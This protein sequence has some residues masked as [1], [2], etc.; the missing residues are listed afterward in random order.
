M[1]VR[2]LPQFASAAGFSS[3]SRESFPDSASP[4]QTELESDKAGRAPISGMGWQVGGA[5]GYATRVAT[6]KEVYK[7]CLD[8]HDLPPIFHYW[9][10]RHI[11]PKLEKFGISTPD[12]LFRQYV[13]ARFQTGTMESRI[14]SLGAGNCQLEVELAL[15]LV[16]EQHE[17]FTIDCLELNTAML[18]RGREAAVKAGVAAHLNFIPMDLNTWRPDNE[19]DTVLAN[20][21]LHHVLN[22]EGLFA[23]VRK[24]LKTGGSFIVS[25]MIGRNGHLRWPEALDLVREFWRRLPPS[26]RFNQQLKRYEEMFE[27]WDCSGDSFEGIRCQ[28]ILPLLIEN[29]HFEFFFAFANIISP[30]VERS[31]GRSFDPATPWDKNFIDEVNER[32]EHEIAEARIQPT[33]LLAVLGADRSVPAVF[34]PLSPQNCL[35]RPARVFIGGVPDMEMGPAYAWG[36]WPHSDRSELEAAC[37]HLKEAQVRIQEEARRVLERTQWA[38]GLSREL[39]SASLTIRALHV[40]LEERTEWARR[41]DSEAAAAARHIQEL[42]ETVTERTNWAARLDRERAELLAGLSART[43]REHLLELDLQNRADHIGN[44]DREIQEGARAHRNDLDRLSWAA[45][46]D[47]RFHGPLDSG[48]RL[49]QRVYKSIRQVFFRTSR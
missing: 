3:A 23:E 11:R 10:N 13:E 9:S 1:D 35:R 43:A 47:R 37:R 12:D 2:K 48:V 44:L 22:L 19:Y 24:S 14:A 42:Q 16:R 29:F 36:A 39:E 38:Q 27:D 17:N 28:D 45:P 31:F 18:E 26:Y 40:E 34:H 6:E 21:I 15:H 33:H 46:F 30:F 25:D 20:Q 41:L 32:D 5:T 4:Q 49:V 8:V 7:D